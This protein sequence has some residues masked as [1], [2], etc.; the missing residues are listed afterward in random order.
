MNKQQKFQFWILIGI[1]AISGF[2]QGMLLPLIAVIFE[3]AGLPSSLNGLNAIALYIGILLASPLMEAPLRKLGYKPMILIGGLIVA[4]SLF[5]F[6]LWQSFWFWFAL[7]FFIGIGDHMLHFASQTWITSFS[8]SENRGKNIALYGLFFGLGFAAGPIMTRLVEINAAWPFQ[9]SSAIALVGWLTVFYVKNEHPE[10]DLETTSIL[11]TFQRFGQVFKYAWVAFLPPFAYGF[12]ETSLNGNFPVYAL[13]LG[14]T[15]DAVSIILPA[16]AIGGIVF[17]LPL[18]MLSDHYGRHKVL[19]WTMLVGFASFA[20]AGMIEHS[21]SGLFI[22][23]FIAGMA[24]GS[25]FSLG[26]SYMADLLPK[27]LLPAGNI[28]CGILFSAGSMAGPLLGGINL[29]L[30]NGTSFFYMISGILLAIFFALFLFSFKE[31]QHRT[32]H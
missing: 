8:Q 14:I 27:N 4:I 25:S 10:Q 7:R 32:G 6:P 28:M 18:G 31:K 13:R 17:Q 5:L 12:L 26:I 20:V 21:T 15:I 23:F 30:T 22:C 2:S 1:V 29:Q 16:F 24:V 19:S 3:K 11:G 9:I